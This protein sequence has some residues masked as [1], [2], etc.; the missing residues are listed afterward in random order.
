MRTT[1]RWLLSAIL[2]GVSALLLALFAAGAF[3]PDPRTSLPA[4]PV[5]VLCLLGWTGS[6]LWLGGRSDGVRD[7]LRK[8]CLLGAVE[9]AALIPAMVRYR[10]MFEA[11]A[12]DPAAGGE[13]PGLQAAGSLATMLSTLSVLMAFGCFC[14]W[15][16]L[17]RAAREHSARSED[18]IET[19]P[20]GPP[21][22]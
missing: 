7:V 10:R 1:G 8:G 15:Y 9:W 19:A 5:Q 2:G 3:Q 20:E 14:G 11:A 12:Q 4:L 17:A 22:D 21:A 6:T 18:D 13:S 16:L